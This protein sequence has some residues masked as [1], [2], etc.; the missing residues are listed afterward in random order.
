MD[1]KVEFPQ[2]AKGETFVMNLTEQAA[3]QGNSANTDT[4]AINVLAPILVEHAQPSTQNSKS[5]MTTK[6]NQATNP[7]DQNEINVSSLPTPICVK[8]LTNLL[9]GY[10]DSS[11]VY[12]LCNIFR[13]GARIGFHGQRTHRFSKNLPTASSNPTIVSSNLANEVSLGRMAGPFV[14]PPFQNFQISPIGLVPK[15]N[16]D[17]F[18]T[19]FHLSYPKSGSTSINSSISKEDFSL[20]YVTVDDAINGIKRFGPGS[21]LAKTDIESAFRLIPVHPDDYKLLGMK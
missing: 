15:K 5:M 8:T 19:I 21:F 6:E 10:P 14:T 4:Y 2:G 11:F 3:V 18:R 16:S 20:Q 17:K 9:S 12:Q 7:P 13:Q 1:P